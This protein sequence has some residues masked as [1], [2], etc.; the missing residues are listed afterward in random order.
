MLLGIDFL[1]L[2][3]Q[4]M[5]AFKKG[6]LL[7]IYLYFSAMVLKIH[8]FSGILSIFFN[9]HFTCTPYI[10]NNFISFPLTFSEIYGTTNN[11]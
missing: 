6:I 8:M 4:C 7:F 5:Y 2:N 10:V 3:F 1:C 9:S 11:N